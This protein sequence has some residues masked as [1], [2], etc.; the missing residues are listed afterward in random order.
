MPTLAGIDGRTLV[1][2]AFSPFSQIAQLLQT[3]QSLGQNQQRIDQQGR[4]IGLSEQQFQNELQNQQKVSELAEQIPGAV[5]KK[6]RLNE[7]MMQLGAINP[8]AQAAIMDVLKRNDDKEMQEWTKEAID[9]SAFFTAVRGLGSEQ[10]QKAAI[11]QRAI[12]F[13]NKNNFEVATELMRIH[14]KD[15][16]DFKLAIMKKAITATG[17]QG[18]MNTQKD[19]KEQQATAKAEF[20]QTLRTIQGTEGDIEKRDLIRQILR[21]REAAGLG[22]SAESQML[23]QLAGTYRPGELDTQLNALLAGAADEFGKGGPKLG[24]DAVLMKKGGGPITFAQQVIGPDGKGRL[25]FNEAPGYDPVNPRTGLG[26][27]AE[28]DIKTDAELRKAQGVKDIDLDMLPKIEGAKLSTKQ[29]LDASNDAFKKL[30]IL[31]EKIGLYDR[32]IDA[33]ERGAGTGP[34]EKMMPTFRAASVELQNIQQQLGLNILAGVTMGALSEREM[35]ILLS[36]AIPTGL[37]GPELKEWL[38]TRKNATIKLRNFIEDAVVYLR[39]PD[40][41][42]EG[43]IAARRGNREATQQT[44]EKPSN[45]GNI[46]RFKMRVK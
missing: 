25:I 20:T 19:I 37:D 33:V 42:L 15:G 26:L 7:L 24:P 28:E 30:P 6:A 41:T 3:E 17:V 9:S 1:P 27:Q 36:T 11:E 21:N 31:D 44:L 10:K 4:L 16:D 2:D 32:A 45:S 8:Q 14:A 13:K 5:N 40:S 35:D 34:I 29:R 18:I 22:E 43:F 23:T 12:D 38:Q 46:G 39:K